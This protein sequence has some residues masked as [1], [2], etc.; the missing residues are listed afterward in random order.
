MVGMIVANRCGILW[1]V[2]PAAGSGM[3]VL[4]IWRGV[5]GLRRK[6]I[7][8]ATPIAAVLALLW[9][10]AAQPVPPATTGAPRPLVPGVLT[11]HVIVISMDGLRPDA[12]ARVRPRTLQRLAREGSHS[13]EAQTIVPSRTLP[14]HMSMVSGEPPH[15]HGVVNNDDPDETRWVVDVPTMF[16]LAH[17][18]GFH[19]AA[20]FSKTKF[21]QIYERGAIDYA[22]EPSNRLALRPAWRTARQVVRYL[23]RERPQ[24]LFIHFGEPDYVGH[25]F[26]W[27]S[28]PY[29]WAVLWTDRAVARILAAADRAFGP[30]QYT[31][32]L[33]ADHGGSRFTHGS[34]DPVDTTIP[35]IAWGKGVR[36]GE[37]LP[38]GLRTMDTA[39]TV[40]WLLGVQ[41]PSDW[42]GVPVTSAFHAN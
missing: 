15:I 1:S 34:S 6:L 29:R 31:V 26:G 30:E 36:A 23:E 32:I 2:P 13:L 7:S 35:W 16:A 3:Q 24:L 41:R 42:V 10:C 17:D 37:V 5:S 22:E 18:S 40:L 28:P 19:T 9:G 12:L 27:M 25:T 4:R 21:R 39:A 38:P 20:F 14:S 8:T 11:S 33:T